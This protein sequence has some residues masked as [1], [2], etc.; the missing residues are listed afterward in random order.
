MLERE[1]LESFSN[2]SSDECLLPFV[3]RSI[4]APLY[5][6]ATS[7]LSSTNST[8]RDLNQINPCK[9][10]RLEIPLP[11]ASFHGRSASKKNSYLL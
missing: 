11:P 9:S 3:A 7:L 2:R 6:L 5:A 1:L 8:G 4:S 10:C